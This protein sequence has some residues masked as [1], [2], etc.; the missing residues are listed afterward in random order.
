MN[1]ENN[2]LLKHLDAPMRIITF[3]VE[4]FISYIIPFFIGVIVDNVC[5]VTIL[6]I[7]LVIF[8][9]KYLRRFPKFYLI[10]LFYWSLPTARFNKAL[11]LNLPSSAKRLWVK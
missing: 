10:G 1:M 8:V 11:K 6:G 4:E 5:L 9:R 7:T 2:V 3:T